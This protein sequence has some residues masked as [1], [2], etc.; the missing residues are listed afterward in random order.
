MADLIV[1]TGGSHAGKTSLVAELASRGY[2]V[3][4]EAAIEVIE[5]LTSVHGVEAQA[6]WRQSNQLEFQRRI[7]TRQHAREH[8]A[9][10]SSAP[11]IFC[12]RGLL[13]G[14]AYCRLAGVDWPDELRTLAEDARYA[15]VFLL[16]TLESF[17]P[18]L[19]TGRVHS[20]EDSL[21][22]EAILETIYL[23]RAVELTRV[24]RVPVTDRA[25]LVLR[26]LGLPLEP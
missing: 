26:Q 9:R 25:D 5:E 16:A 17:D 3:L 8:A 23:P 19:E 20:H 22:I 4:P 6:R 24:P 21:R 12:D 1:I 14:E 18:R 7:T 13:D 15:H 10:E 2:D 11:V